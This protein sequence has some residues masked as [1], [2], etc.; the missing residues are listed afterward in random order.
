[1]LCSKPFLE[2]SDAGMSVLSH[3]LT[4]CG[5]SSACVAYKIDSLCKHRL[6][7]NVYR[8]RGIAAKISVVYRGSISV[9]PGLFLL[10]VIS[11]RVV[12]GR[13]RQK[14]G[15]TSLSRRREVDFGHIWPTLLTKY[16]KLG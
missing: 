16:N 1:M 7:S 13:L 5:Y 4:D 11:E 14:R 10:P 3:S 2:R 6:H 15:R 8:S 12:D 9:T